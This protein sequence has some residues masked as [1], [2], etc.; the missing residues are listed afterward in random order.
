MTVFADTSAL[1]AVLDADDR[2]HA[3]ARSVWTRLL[4]AK[5]RLVT[6]NYVLVETHALVRTRLG[7][8]ALR[9]LVED[10]LPVLDGF[11]TEPIIAPA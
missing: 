9:A 11:T 7:F 2:H 4:D 3:R 1:L 5:E 10:V 6:G 8:P